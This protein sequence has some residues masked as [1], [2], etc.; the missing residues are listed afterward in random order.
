MLYSPAAEGPCF[1]LLSP[2][3]VLWITVLGE[4]CPSQKLCLP[5]QPLVPSVGNYHHS[6]LISLIFMSI[7]TFFLTLTVFHGLCKGEVT[8]AV[9]LSAFVEGRGRAAGDRSMPTTRAGGVEKT[10]GYCHKHVA[11]NNC[12]CCSLY[13]SR[14]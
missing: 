7:Q 3:P 5:V 1:T 12:L 14:T 13:G 11:S 4:M 8:Q 9:I 2:V 10:S 6:E